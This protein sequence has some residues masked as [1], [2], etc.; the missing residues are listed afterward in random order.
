MVI[1]GGAYCSTIRRGP[2][3]DNALAGEPARGARVTYPKGISD[4]DLLSDWS[5]CFGAAR[6]IFAAESEAGAK[7]VVAFLDEVSIPALEEMIV[8]PVLRNDSAVKTSGS[9]TWHWAI[10][11]L[12]DSILLIR[13]GNHP[14]FVVYSIPPQRIIAR[15]GIPSL[16][17]RWPFTERSDMC[18]GALASWQR[19]SPMP[20]MQE[21]NAGGRE[22]PVAAHDSSIRRNESVLVQAARLLQ[23]S[24]TRCTGLLVGVFGKN[25]CRKMIPPC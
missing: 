23:Q 8:L 7:L 14:V 24:T 21:S 1:V 3:F 4:A 5:V 11:C 25:Y 2:M 6:P 13:A 22:L 16:S 17:R 19:R 18:L 9:L 15:H 20:V 10:D 12:A